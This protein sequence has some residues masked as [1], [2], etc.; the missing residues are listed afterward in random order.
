MGLLL[1]LGVVT[2]LLFLISTAT[3]HRELEHRMH[4]KFEGIL[5]PAVFQPA[6]TL[7]EAHFLW[8]DKVLVQSGDLK[9]QYDPFF[10]IKGTTLRVR[11]SSTLI[12]AELL[13]EW[14]KLQGVRQIHAQRFVAD[15]DFNKKGIEDIYYLDLLSPEFQFRIK[16]SET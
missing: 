12:S 7:K 1:F 5:I 15:L 2:G 14:Q 16:K 10:F 9:I 3:V 4:L 11:I 8:E 13:G 6:Y